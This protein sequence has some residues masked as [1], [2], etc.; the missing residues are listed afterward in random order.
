MLFGRKQK[1]TKHRQN[2]LISLGKQQPNKE[3]RI[4]VDQTHAYIIQKAL[5]L[6]IPLEGNCWDKNAISPGTS[7]M[8]KLTEMVSYTV[9]DRS[10]AF[11]ES[12]KYHR[13]AMCSIVR[14]RCL[15]NQTLDEHLCNIC[16]PLLIIGFCSGSD[17]KRY[18]NTI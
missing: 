15:V 12:V 7:F 18:L 16:T 1:S 6:K 17:V 14:A 11:P 9:S 10:R 4:P 8:N 3:C 2:K 5:N 13:E